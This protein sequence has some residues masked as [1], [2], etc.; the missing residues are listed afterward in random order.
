M[1]I[2]SYVA[3]KNED[4]FNYKL[5][6]FYGYNLGLKNEFKRRIK[7]KFT[8]SIISISQDEIFKHEDVFYNNLFNI[9][10][11]DENKI[12][13]VDQCDDK[14][15]QIVKE[16]ENKLKNQKIFLFANQLDKKSKLRNYF[17][18]SKNYSIIA[19]YEDNEIN[20]KK[21]IM[22]RLKNFKGLTERSIKLIIDSCNLDRS[23]LENEIQKIS[24]LF[25]KN[26]IDE[27]KLKELLNINTN[28][29][30]NLLKDQT[31]NGDKVK[32]NRLINNTIL[33]PEKNV[34][35]LNIINHRLNKLSEINHNSNSVGL[36][37]AINMIKPPIFWKDKAN[38]TLQATKWD[39]KKINEALNKTYELE[40]L[41]KSNSS[42]NRQLLMK[43][44]L[45]DICNIANA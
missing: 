28:E 34:L 1:I 43:K 44:L 42:I 6:L 24:L 20:I 11:F 40:L 39:R 21:I 33:E 5:L 2:K 14:F 45:I 18:N 25:D 16:I 32:T 15:I 37:Q 9:S 8:T 29:D 13:I 17:E 31:L 41:I 27:D 38:F 4:L 3:E 36:E 19:C 23:K 12:F 7:S 22:E 30:F 35:Y 10:L 26:I